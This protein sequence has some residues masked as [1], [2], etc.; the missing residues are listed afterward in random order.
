MNSTLAQLYNSPEMYAVYNQ[1]YYW[2][3]DGIDFSSCHEDILR[4]LYHGPEH[5]ILN[6]QQRLSDFQYL[7]PEM[8]EG[9]Q[10]DRRQAW[11]P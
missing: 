3:E 10:P 7:C 1:L 2:K 9:S 6:R 4:W 8:F 11:L 5:S